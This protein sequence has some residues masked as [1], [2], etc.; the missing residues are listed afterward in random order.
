M[1]ELKQI[2][3]FDLKNTEI[4]VEP[5]LESSYPK[6]NMLSQT[7]RRCDTR[8]IHQIYNDKYNDNGIIFI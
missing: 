3:L 4:I 6:S 7:A 5:D 8:Y 1:P 2:K